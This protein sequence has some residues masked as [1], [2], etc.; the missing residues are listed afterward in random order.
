M[1]PGGGCERTPLEEEV[2]AAVK[3]SRLQLRVL[4]GLLGLLRGRLEECLG[5]RGL[6][7]VVEAEGSY[8]KGTVTSDKWELDVFL[9]IEGVGGE[10]IRRHGEALLLDCLR[11]LPVEARYAEHPYVTVRL[12]GVEADVVVAPLVSRP[13]EGGTGVERTPFHT[14]WLRRAFQEKPCLADD[15]RLFKAFLKGIGAYG[16][17][18]RVGGFSGFLAELLVVYHGGFRPLLR[19]AARWRPGAYVDPLGL[20]DPG[21]L[22]RRYPDSALIVPDPTDPERNAAAAVTPRR[23]ADLVLAANAYLES[24]CRLFFHPYST[25]SPPPARADP[26]RVAALELR[27]DYTREA[28]DALWGR[29]SRLASWL[30]RGLEAGGFRVLRV[31]AWTDEAARALVAVEAESATLPPIELARGPPAWSPRRALSYIKRRLEQG[32]PFT[33]GP[34]GTLSGLKPR[35][36][37]R[38]EEALQALASRPDAPTPRGTSTVRVHPPGSPGAREAAGLLDEATPRWP[39]CLR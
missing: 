33:V 1:E 38:L 13:G 22:R 10:W 32:M 25:A 27:G 5:R 36:H 3:P 31:E 12:M 21:R 9:L 17:E 24:P 7:G 34:D 37:T 19:A 23:L 4:G 14:R 29:L 6:R 8:A 11:G 26:S 35:R 15:A 39:L 30:A 16:A 20:G 28:R 2:L 18:T